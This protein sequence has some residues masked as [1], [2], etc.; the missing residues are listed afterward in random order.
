MS[1]TGH[2][3]IVATPIG[4]LDDMVPRAMQTLKSVDFIAAEDTRHS[5]KL[6]KHFAID[7]PMLAY[8]EHNES[9]RTGYL[10][11]LLDSGSSVALI[12]D[13]G[14]P[15]I[16]DPGYRLVRAAHAAGIN[17]T[18][19]PGPSAMVAALSVSGLPSDQVLFVGFLPSR[20]QS[21]R[22]RL[23]ELAE[24]RETVVL[25]ESC[26]RIA[27]ALD[28]MVLMLGSQREVAFC[29]EL[30]KTFETVR[31]GSL[32]SIRDWVNADNDQQ[33]GEIVLVIEG[34]K[35]AAVSLDEVSQD[36]LRALAA[37]MAPARAAALASRVTGIRKRTLYEWL[38]QGDA[39]GGK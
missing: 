19:I 10:V 9:E 34:N 11:G 15:L 5:G 21:R 25:Y 37:E 26:H 17:V 31:L 18:P 29:R 36:W 38:T 22:A 6:L 33:R 4:N 7:T 3:Y 39:G 16:S 35:A 30:T 32:E 27:D 13:A 20:V 28:D 1:S 24:R 8:H 23:Q 12:S 14:T 2:L